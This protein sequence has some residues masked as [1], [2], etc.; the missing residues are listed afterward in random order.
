MNTG[1]RRKI[2]IA[3]DSE[4]NRAILVDML[5]EEFDLM[6]A[7][8]G[9]EV[10][11]TLAYHR[12]DIDL[13]LLDV[14]MPEMDGF[15]VLNVMNG[16]QWTQDVPVIMISAETGSKYVERAFQLGASDYVSRP[17]VPDIVYR[18]IINTITLHAKKRKL[19]EIVADQFYQKERNNDMVVSILS[20]V[21]EFRDG[22]GGLHVLHVNLLTELLLK[23]LTQKTDQY[24][25]GKEDMEAIQTASSLHDMGKILVPEEILTKPGPLTE[26]EKCIMHR[27]AADGAR[28]IADLPIYKEERLVKYAIE[29]CH[30]HHE[31]WDGSGYPDGLKGDEIPIA[32][33]VVGLADVLD[34]LTS[35]RCYKGPYSYEEAMRMIL[36]GECGAFNPLLIQCLTE[37][38]DALPRELAA[39]SFLTQSRRVARKVV[40]ELYDYR[41]PSSLRVSQ[42]LEE[43]QSK[44]RFLKTLSG[45]MWFEFTTGP[46][47]LTLSA[48]AAKALNLPG[49]IVD[50][51]EDARVVAA[52]GK[53]T[54]SRLRDILH[55]AD[56]EEKYLELEAELVLNGE[57]RW[58]QITMGV[59]WSAENVGKCSSLVGKIVDIHDRYQI[60]ADCRL[61]AGDAAPAPLTPLLE[62]GEV[63]RVSKEQVPGLLWGY[64]AMFGVARLVDPE[65]CMQLTLDERGQVVEQTAS[66][67]AVWSKNQRCENCISQ[68][69]VAT[70]KA[71][72]KLET[73]KNE[74]Y[75]VVSSY[76]EVEGKPYAL[77][78]A[79]HLDYDTMLAAGEKENILNQLL[80]RNR[81][82]YLDSVTRV[83]NRRYYD[84]RLK[85][86]DGEFAFAMVDMDN[87]KAI[88]DTYGHLAGDMALYRAAQSI[89]GAIRNSDELVRYGGDEFFLLFHDM[90]KRE[91]ERKLQA[92]RIALEKIEFP[93]YPGLRI[94]ASIGGAYETG[95]IGKT[96]RKADIAMYEAKT[97][98]DC[99]A[100]YQG[101]NE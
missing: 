21:M 96:I 85:D 22:V 60:L 75:F 69:V 99:V 93:E 73:L 62:S 79:S 67:Y 30:W 74:V 87:F 3:D 59:S 34:A 40:D 83:Y 55:R 29:I 24:Q 91:F 18:R 43:E 68:R 4:L 97:T 94:S 26:T 71:Q 98:K 100:I 80:V 28:I 7:A 89:K 50:P 77:E 81:Q 27:H 15:E 56:L 49:V 65:I 53:D 47:A 42:Q 39:T 16:E 31:R 33:Q 2:L 6:E 10:I 95:V 13:V 90:P 84:E 23:S 66:C 45:E 54:I 14:V 101:G 92:I 88:N 37:L 17:F 25:L 44:A 20:H 5:E 72:T 41:G 36:S 9:R 35:S 82:V 46:E 11:S 12:K 58:C 8:D 57:K 63:L 61:S 48:L 78:L 32:A 52:V 70:H 38:E 86:L 1:K 19:L 76:V 64:R 51:R